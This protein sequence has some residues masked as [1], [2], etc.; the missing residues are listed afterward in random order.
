[1]AKRNKKRT[2]TGTTRPVR[3]TAPRTAPKTGKEEGGCKYPGYISIDI[4]SVKRNPEERRRILFAITR[5]YQTFNDSVNWKLFEELARHA[6]DLNVPLEIERIVRDVHGIRK[7]T[8]KY[9]DMARSDFNIIEQHFQNNLGQIK[10]DGKV[11]DNNSN[12]TMTNELFTNRKI[13]YDSIELYS[14]VTSIKSQLWSRAVLIDRTIQRNAPITIEYSTSLHFFFVHYKDSNGY[15]AGVTVP[16]SIPATA[17]SPVIIGH[18]IDYQTFER[19]YKNNSNL[20]IA[21]DIHLDDS[22]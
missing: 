1:M 6:G 17:D 22:T 19:N 5:W 16:F 8:Q 21:T 18:S 13:S 9:E 11:V 7:I 10:V 20:I 12:V 3:R 15:N 4:N 2:G 14:K